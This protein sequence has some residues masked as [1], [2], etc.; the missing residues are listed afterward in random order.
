MSQRTRRALIA[1]WLLSALLLVVL[2][3]RPES[4]TSSKLLTLCCLA[5]LLPAPFVL[6]WKRRAIRIAL[7]ATLAGAV[8]LLLL[9]GRTRSP[10]ELTDAYLAHLR[11]FDGTH[12]VWGGEN[13]RGIDCSGLVR[14]SLIEASLER[15][16]TQVDPSL[17]RQ[18]ATVWWFDASAQALGEGYRGLTTEILRSPSLR[19]IDPS[20]LR[21]GDLAVTADGTHVLAYL[22]DA[23]WIQADPVP[24]RV[25]FDRIS[26]SSGWFGVP[27]VIWRWAT[28]S[29]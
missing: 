25:H 8:L 15:A 10:D 18:A 12:Y 21:R 20:L 16:V 26:E 11:A 9:P 5:S 23:T 3:V 14:V 4:T 6:F 7:F 17:L 1:L 2:F 28:L 22:G 19:A 24:M 13:H 27:V 29:P